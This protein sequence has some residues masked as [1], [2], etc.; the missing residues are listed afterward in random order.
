MNDK[1]FRK[2]VLFLVSIVFL[3][4]CVTPAQA[5]YFGDWK[6]DGYFKSQFGI[7]TET[8][9]F[10]D[11]KFGGSDDN[12]ATARQTFRWNLEGPLSKSFALRAEVMAVWEPDYPHE[13]GVIQSAPTRWMDANNYNSFDWREL[14]IEYKPNYSHSIKF[15]RQII[16]WGEALSGRVLDQCNPSDSRASVGFLSLEDTYIPLWMFRG[17]HDFY[18]FYS[19]SIEWIAAPIWQADRFEAGRSADSDTPVG[20]GKTTDSRGLSL[21]GTGLSGAAYRNDPGGRFSAYRDNRVGKALGLGADISLNN[22]GLPGSIL[23]PP[24]ST[25]YHASD[26]FWGLGIPGYTTGDPIHALSAGEAAMAVNIVQSYLPP[27]ATTLEYITA[28]SDKDFVFLSET[29]TFIATDYTDHNFKNTRWGFKTKSQIGEFEGG[30]AFFQGPGSVITKIVDYEPSGLPFSGYVVLQY[31]IPRYDTYGLY[32]N[33]TL[34]GTKWWFE[35]AYQP[36]Y[37]VHKDLMGIGRG[38]DFNPAVA[39]SVLEQRLDNMK[40]IDKLTTLWGISREQWITPLNAYNVF[41]INFQY[42]NTWYLGDTDGCVYVAP[43]FME[44][45][46]MSHSFLLSVSTSYSYGKYAPGLTLA[47]YPEGCGLVSASFNYRPDILNGN[48]TFSLGYSNYW[49]GPE[50]AAGLSLYQNNDTVTVGFK[51]NIYE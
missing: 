31:Q 30:I 28:N 40:E 13:K 24:Y 20:D 44:L 33:T 26:M 19:T 2:Y 3:L 10:N 45:D 29:P 47:Y 39:T 46:Q 8:K 23:G 42:T 18:Q 27:G 16:N 15:G 14:T 9:P 48:L 17:Q 12:I 37:L 6:T 38:S 7:F 49:T 1:R 43:Y 50:Y 4:L 41:S 35:A 32:G 34:W 25:G 22:L 51:Y 11:A 36:D 5:Y 21:V